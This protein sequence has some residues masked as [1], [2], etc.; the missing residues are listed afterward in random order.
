MGDTTTGTPNTPVPQ[1]IDYNEWYR[2]NCS[3]G[4]IYLYDGSELGSCA[5][6]LDEAIDYCVSQAG[7]IDAGIITDDADYDNKKYFQCYM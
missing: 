7:A 3:D 6:K 4:Y 2:G 1:N 5:R